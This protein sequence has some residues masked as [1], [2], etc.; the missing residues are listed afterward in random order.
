MIF[1]ASVHYINL[2]FER[3]E[4]QYRSGIVNIVTVA[5][6]SIEPIVQ[7]VRS[8]ELDRDQAIARIRELLRTMKYI[9][10]DGK[11]YVFMSDYDGIMLVQ[12]YEP[13][14]EMTDQYN[15]KDA[16]GVYII[17]ELIKA[18]KTRPGGSFVRYHYMRSPD[19]AGIEEK[20]SYVVGIPEIRCYIGTG[21]YLKALVDQQKDILFN[22]AV[23]QILL[24]IISVVPIIIS[25]SMLFNRNR[26][27]RD[28]IATRIKAEEQNRLLQD[29]INQSQKLDAIGQLAGGVAHDFNNILMGIGGT[30]ALLLMNRSPDDPDCGDLR[31]IEEYVA[32]G[33]KLTAQLLGFARG[34]KCEI[35]ALQI[36]E[37]L[38]RSAG[39]FCETRKEIGLVFDLDDNLPAV[40]ADSGQMDQVL[41]NLYINAAHAMPN[42][43]QLTIK[44]RCEV[45][46]QSA[47]KQK[48]LSPGKYAVVTVADTGIGMDRETLT[49]IFEPFFTTKGDKGGRGLGL[50][51]AYGIIINHEGAI[52]AASE[53]GRGSVF[54]LFLPA[55]EKTP[56][57]VNDSERADVPHDG[58]GCIL[59]IDDEEMILA[60]ASLLLKR[61]GFDVL[62]AKTEDEAFA[63][64]S[65]KRGEIRLV[66]LD[67]ILKG[68]SGAQL[69]KKLREID[70]EV[71]VILS[72]GY[73]IEGEVGRVMESGCRGFI[74][75]PYTL[76]ELSEAIHKAIL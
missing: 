19:E 48:G 14:K 60:T 63:L 55:S 53:P 9:D 71:R 31:S 12:P 41:L 46:E 8:G 67:M 62:T 26:L 58:N 75:K 43:G 21:M 38:V 45:L 17:Q 27:L 39:F 33:A 76:A 65:E 11:N 42:G 22:T 44:S 51:S 61:I 25:I 29:Q 6:N 20:L 18:A 15:L 69:L 54:T 68:T 73:G 24:L 37:L 5:R 56:E 1:F 47:A 23:I 64:F 66:I 36:N 74:Q 70:Q 40:E 28:E 3:V 52:E 13:E 72:S 49:R 35:K 10:H 2:V 16:F 57:S 50:A 59:L 34:G 32:R 30:A 4:A 7:K